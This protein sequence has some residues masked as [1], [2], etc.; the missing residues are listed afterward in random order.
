MNSKKYHYFYKITNKINGHFY[1][2][3]HS[4]NNLNDGYMGSGKRLH[5]AYLKYGIENF[6]KEI[7]KFFDTRE[8][9]AQYEAEM[10]TESSILDSNCYNII[11][12]G[13]KNTTM[14]TA[15]VKDIKGNVY[16]VPVSDERILTG[17]L[18]GITKGFVTAKNK[19]GKTCHV[20]INDERY[21]SGELIPVMKGACNVVDK[22]GR[23][24]RIDMND[25]S[26]I[27]GDVIPF[28]R[29]KIL[30]KD[31]NQKCCTVFKNDERFKNG[32]LT[33]F[34]AGKKHKEETKQKISETFKQNKHQQ[35]EKNSQYGTCWITKNGINKKIKKI[36]IDEYINLGWI[37]GR[38]MK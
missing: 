36:D 14:G 10:V 31:K 24:F 37:K 3:I 9:A 20:S 28:N 16:Q 22:N 5:K 21:K 25:E 4:T 7:K 32:E 19:D 26:Y 33:S 11:L 34:W 27:N 23:V 29:G 12:G 38:K 18:V 6:F 1:Y 35:G 30:V 2:G 13:E 17:E 15:T 8:E